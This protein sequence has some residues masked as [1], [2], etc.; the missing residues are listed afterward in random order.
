MVSSS[1]CSTLEW[2]SLP[3]PG[4]KAWSAHLQTAISENWDV[5]NQLRERVSELWEKRCRITPPVSVPSHSICV[6]HSLHLNMEQESF[7]FFLERI[8]HGLMTCVQ[9]LQLKRRFF[10]LM[11]QPTQQT[12]QDY[13]LTTYFMQF[14]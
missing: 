4:S 12:K 5:R 8:S 14:L 6:M 9:L 2:S 1:V 13:S 7:E 3:L 10:F 11:N